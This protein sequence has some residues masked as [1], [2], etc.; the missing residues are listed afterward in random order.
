MHKRFN[1]CFL[2]NLAGRIKEFILNHTTNKAARI[3]VQD[4]Q[5]LERLAEMFSKAA[6]KISGASK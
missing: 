5:A 6:N 1:Q 2:K 3:F 4:A